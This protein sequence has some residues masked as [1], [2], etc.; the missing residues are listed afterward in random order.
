M[1]IM[2]NDERTEEVPDPIPSIHRCDDLTFWS[3]AHHP[4]ARSWWSSAACTDCV[5][6]AFALLREHAG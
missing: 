5:V 1:G 2:R 4:H 3:S 6:I